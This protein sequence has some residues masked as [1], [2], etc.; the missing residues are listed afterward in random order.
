MTNPDTNSKWE[1]PNDDHA[2]QPWYKIYQRELG[3]FALLV[4]IFLIIATWLP[5]KLAPDNAPAVANTVAV[6]EEPAKDNVPAPSPAAVASP[7]P[8]TLESPWQDAQTAKARREAQE[9]LAKLVDRQNKLEA[10][11]VN[12][13]ADTAYRAAQETAQQADE[14]YKQ[15]QFLQ[16]Q[17]QYQEALEAFDALIEQSDDHFQN[18]LKQGFA[19]LQQHQPQ[20][21][22]PAFE[23]ATA[24]R[25][26]DTAARQGLA[27]AQNLPQLINLLNQARNLE[28]TQQ[29]DP[30]LQQATE[31]VQL[32]ADDQQAQQIQKRLQLAITDRD[33]KQAMG[34]AYI[35]IQNNQINEARKQFLAAQKL[36]PQSSAP[37]TGIEQLNNQQQ[38][39]ALKRLFDNAKA[40]EAKEQWQ[41]A[42]SYYTKAL[43]LDKSLIQAK[44]GQLRSSARAKLHNQL[45]AQLEQPLRLHSNNVFNQAQSVLQDARAI[46]QPGPVLQ[47]QI[48][49]L[50]EML[51]LAR[52]PVGVTLRSDNATQVTVYKVGSFG[53]FSEQHLELIPGRYVAVGS[54][55]GYRDVRKE[56]TISPSG[57]RT[58]VW[59]QCTEKIALDS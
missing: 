11:A 44:V 23:L 30:A 9:I 18:T 5:A 8:A 53:E 14:V 12:L 21:A 2:T 57:T 43:A 28:S 22:L 19:A 54:R 49:Q 32:D 55:Q 48:S 3:L 31:A 7:T 1:A 39:S 40:S 50:D 56:F 52:R 37:A 47:Q 42:E 46:K 10:I 29:L 17:Q 25:P 35:A 13:W 6:A 51:V 41:A 16:A 38:R 33:F 20:A 24:M 15:R 34:R 4:V 27:R 45:Q 36:K 26:D 58:S 59:I